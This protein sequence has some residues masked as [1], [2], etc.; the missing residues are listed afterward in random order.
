[1]REVRPG[2][3]YPRGACFDGRGV[4]FAVYSSVASRIEVCLFDPAQPDREVER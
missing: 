4:N 3:P 2:R 1:M